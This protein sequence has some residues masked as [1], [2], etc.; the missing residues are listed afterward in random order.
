MD[1]VEICTR[2]HEWTQIPIIIL[3]IRDSERD[4]VGALDPGAD[5]YFTKPFCKQEGRTK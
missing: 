5:D 1:G 3:S 4:K 2:L